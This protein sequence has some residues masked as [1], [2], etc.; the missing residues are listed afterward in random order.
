MLLGEDLD[1][2][3]DEPSVSIRWS[4]VACGG[5]FVLSGSSGIHGSSLC[6][7][8]NIPLNIYVDG[9]VKFSTRL[10]TD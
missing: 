6:G 10:L 4:I 1:I 7:L 2:D 8:P 5:N 9:S 3:I